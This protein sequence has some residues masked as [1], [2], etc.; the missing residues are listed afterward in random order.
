MKN[1]GEIV[2]LEDE[3]EEDARPNPRRRAGGR[4]RLESAALGGAVVVGAA[5]V[6]FIVADPKVEK[7]VQDQIVKTPGV[8]SEIKSRNTAGLGTLLAGMGI[9]IAGF[10][11]RSGARSVPVLG[12]ALIG[13]GA[14]LGVAGAV[15]LSTASKLKKVQRVMA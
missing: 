3:V 4:K 14:G 5:G 12:E 8:D 10:Y 6:T 11:V 2:E 9:A 13:A 15:Q 1:K 7:W